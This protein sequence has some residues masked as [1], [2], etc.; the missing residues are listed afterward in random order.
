MNFVSGLTILFFTIGLIIGSFLNAV[1]FR[2]HKKKSFL[3]GRSMCMTCSHQ[4]SWYELIP[5]ISFI[6]QK[7]KCRSCKKVISIQYPLVEF[8]VGLLFVLMFNLATVQYGVFNVATYVATGMYWFFISVLT[9]LF[10]FDFRW[11]IIPDIVSIPAMIIVVL[12]QLLLIGLH[13]GVAVSDFLIYAFDAG[14]GVLIGGGF[15]LIQF[16]ISRGR[17]IGGGD[18]RLGIL[19]GLMLGWK[20]TVVGLMLA[21]V[22]GSIIAIALILFGNKVWSS[23]IPFGTFLSIASVVALVWGEQI[24]QWYL[25]YF[26]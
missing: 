8:F 4:L 7:G 3:K 12:F 6:L 14:I 24:I 10:V 18:I 16:L 21:Y 17:W 5:L 25:G 19:M 20:L 26:V 22:G 9:I 2:I 13:R 23:R 15:F 1:I 11:H